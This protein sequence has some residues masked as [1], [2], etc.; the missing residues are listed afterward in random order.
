MRVVSGLARSLRLPSA[1]QTVTFVAGL[2]LLVTFFHI[3]A[4]QDDQRDAGVE[5][6]HAAYPGAQSETS[7]IFIEDANRA[8]LEL[9]EEVPDQSLWSEK[10]ILEYTESHEVG[11][12]PP[13]AVL[14]IQRLAIQVP[15]YDG[16]DDHNLNR[17][18]ARVLGTA[19]VGDQGN[20]GIAGHRDGF[21]RPL[22]D[23]QQG[24]QLELMTPQGQILYH[25]VKTQIVNPE[26]V[27][28]LA[29]TDDQTITLVT[30]FPF[31]WVG[32]APQRFI[33]SAVAESSTSTPK[34]RKL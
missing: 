28:V 15:V 23:I 4:D 19:R 17:G 25:V 1:F 5:A 33:V 8:G 12:E 11:G 16:A 20:L 30:C 18:V 32:D 2:L 29:P 26:D 9:P 7:P 31:Y 3:R 34:E 21:F 13:L 22:K 27:W 10:R 14:N 24:D 6:F